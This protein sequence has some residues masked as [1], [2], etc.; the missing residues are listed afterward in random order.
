MAIVNFGRED[1]EGKSDNEIQQRLLK[2]PVFHANCVLIGD[3][4]THYLLIE[5]LD[6]AA[7]AVGKESPE[8]EYRQ[9]N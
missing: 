2:D 3:R 5:D 7:K 4:F 8:A 6:N 9:P 1:F